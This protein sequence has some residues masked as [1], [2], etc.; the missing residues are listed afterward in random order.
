[1]ANAEIRVYRTTDGELVRENDPRGAFLAYPVGDEIKASE[2]DAYRALVDGQRSGHEV[3]GLM[4]DQLA[5]EIADASREAAHGSAK[6]QETLRTVAELVDADQIE[7]PA[8]P[9]SSS[10][11]EIVRQAAADAKDEPAQ[12]ETSTTRTGRAKAA[13]KP[14]DKAAAKPDDK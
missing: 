4:H 13:A 12:D 7:T 10:P 5:T 11:S 14:S 9:G 2:V 3:P 6:A 1:V 8:Q